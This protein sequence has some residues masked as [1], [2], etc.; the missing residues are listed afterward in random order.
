[1]EHPAHHRGGQNHPAP[2]AGT[3]HQPA[4]ASGMTMRT[5]TSATLGALLVL[6]TGCSALD[7]VIPPIDIRTDVKMTP[8]EAR[9]DLA[10]RSDDVQKLIGGVWENHDNFIASAC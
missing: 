10:R 5:G 3:R 4:S 2:H 9:L 1:M 6:L 7:S 8:A